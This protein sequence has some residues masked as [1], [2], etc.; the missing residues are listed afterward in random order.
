MNDDQ[1]QLAD[2][3]LDE[4]RA[5]AGKLLSEWETSRESRRTTLDQRIG[6][7]ETEAVQ[8]IDRE[9]KRIEDR[10]HAQIVM[11][12]RRAQ[13]R[14]QDSVY[15]TVEH[16]AI[17]GV[18]QLIGDPGYD[19]ILQGWISEACIGLGAERATIT[20]S[21]PE[22][23]AVSRVLSMALK[24]ASAV[25]GKTVHVTLSN[26]EPL[27]D[28]GIVLISEDG[29]TGFSNLVNDRIRRRRGAI[30]RIVYDKLFGDERNAGTDRRT[31]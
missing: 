14:L 24:Q 18:R 12:R 13:L 25:T 8:R 23:E 3:I 4:A 6:N 20:C 16:G 1:K 11:E 17:D 22:K 30:R 9:K 2:G 28:Q 19:D 5:E 29:K 27:T 26:E 15:R 7:L 31:N 21:S 10:T